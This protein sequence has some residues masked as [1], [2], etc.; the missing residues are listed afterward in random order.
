MLKQHLRQNPAAPLADNW[1]GANLDRWGQKYLGYLK[2][3]RQMGRRV[4]VNWEAFVARPA[5]H[6][7]RLSS[8]LDIPLDPTCLDHIRIAHFIGGNTGVDVRGLKVDPT[9]VLRASNAPDL[10]AEAL[11]QAMEHPFAN[12]MARLLDGEYRRDFPEPPDPQ[13]GGANG[14]TAARRR[15]ITEGGGPSVGRNP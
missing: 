3:I 10:P 12:W 13:P 14:S 7:R 5:G 15:V 1:V 2:T 6:M 11:E 4:V 8:L 9:L